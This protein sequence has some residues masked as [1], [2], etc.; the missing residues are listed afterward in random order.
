MKM[1]GTEH[2]TIVDVMVLLLICL[3]VM[4]ANLHCGN[5]SGKSFPTAVT[6]FQFE[7][8]PVEGIIM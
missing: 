8:C 2:I 3:V 4:L 7:V 5:V 1:G 6:R